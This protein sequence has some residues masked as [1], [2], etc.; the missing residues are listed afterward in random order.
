MNRLVILSDYGLDDAVALAHLLEHKSKWSGID[1]VAIAGNT[2]AENSLHNAKKLLSNYTGDLSGVRL[3]DT[4]AKEQTYAHLPSIHGKDGMGDLLKMKELTVPVAAY[5]DWLDTVADDISLVSLGPAPL[6]LEVLGRAGGCPLLIMGGMVKAVPNY[7]GYEFNQAL[8][9]KAFA[10]LLKHP[11]VVATLDTCRAGKF[12]LAFAE[13]K[14]RSLKSR[15]I[16]RAVKLAVTR[17][18]DN[19]FIYDYIAVQYLTAPEIFDVI[20]I[21]DPWGNYLHELVVRPD[22]I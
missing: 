16:R 15:L 7:E 4:T 12:N 13:I 11:H 22:Y 17:H 14:G 21:F 6:A 2:S 8:D 1:V 9:V 18:P 19:C 3:V 5:A 20:D 10:E